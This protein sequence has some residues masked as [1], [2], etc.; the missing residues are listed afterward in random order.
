M[1]GFQVKRTVLMGLRS[2]WLHRLRSLLTVMGM[3]FGVCSVVAMLAIGEGASYE[4]QEQI[5]RLGSTNIIIK[6]VKPPEQRAQS[7]GGNMTLPEY[8]LTYLD[9]ERIRSTIPTVSVIVPVRTIRKR[10]RFHGKAADAALMGTVPWYPEILNRKVANG[11]FLTSTDLYF[12]A[13][14]CVLEPE[15]AQ[16]IFPLDDPISK[17][18]R[19]GSDYYR[20]IGVMASRATG[21]QNGTT[22]SE[23]GKEA[24]IYIPLTTARRRF[25]E[26][27]I[28]LRSGSYMAERV[29]LHELTVKVEDTQDVIPTA[30]A[31][32][33]ILEQEHKK[34][35]Y[36]LVVPLKLLEEARKIKRTFNIVLG[37]IAAISLVV[38]GIGIMNIMLA[39]ITERTREIGIRRALGAKRRHI[40]IQ[41]LTETVLLSGSGGL[42]GVAFGVVIPI[43]VEEFSNMKT[44]VTL[45]SLLLS[46]GISAMVGIVFGIYPA[47]RAANMN[48]IEAL[49]HE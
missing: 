7:D 42:I 38:G 40:V 12:N 25:G 47:Y 49:R 39:T 23:G 31:L 16:E 24:G 5:K 19:V 30:E 2:L 8:G 20:V 18:L 37:S 9:A 22:L 15:I 27:L 41:F 13:T 17:M 4:A 48:P 6:S 45:W 32:Q 34:K 43:L 44:I 28:E 10:V 36:E 3:V 33:R 26:I 14:V 21:K 11:R 29:E 35:D 46:F 1:I